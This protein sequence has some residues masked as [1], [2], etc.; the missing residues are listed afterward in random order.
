MQ[1]G[2]NPTNILLQG[3]YYSAAFSSAAA[4]LGDAEGTSTQG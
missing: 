1:F 3:Y 2:P 4:C